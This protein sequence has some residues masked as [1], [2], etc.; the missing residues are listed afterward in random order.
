MEGT[1][2][3]EMMREARDAEKDLQRIRWGGEAQAST[4]EGEAGLRRMM[5]EQSYKQGIMGTSLLSG[6]SQ[7]GAMYYKGKLKE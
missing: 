3:M 4:Y 5:G 2:L 1:P 6:A 7:I